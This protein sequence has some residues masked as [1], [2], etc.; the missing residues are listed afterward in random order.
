M[1]AQSQPPTPLHVGKAAGRA[2][3]AKIVS[4]VENQDIPFAVVKDRN[5]PVVAIVRTASGLPPLEALLEALP[6]RVLVDVHSAIAFT[7]DR[8]VDPAIYRE[9]ASQIC[10]E[11]E[12]RGWPDGWWKDPSVIPG[13][14]VEGDL[15]SAESD[16]SP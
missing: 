11:G 2:D 8:P 14:E 3:F 12:K 10:R 7:A 13:L 15:R 1:N 9:V 6:S 5:L 4:L 16:G